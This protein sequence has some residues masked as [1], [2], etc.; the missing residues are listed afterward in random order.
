MNSSETT[1]EL[2]NVPD[3]YQI[4]VKASPKFNDINFSL[5]GNDT[6]TQLNNDT[7]TFQGNLR[8]FFLWL[9]LFRLVIRNEGNCPRHWKIIKFARCTEHRAF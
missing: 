3:S 7:F 9:Q 2:S 4:E 6:A 8:E 1:T 5:I